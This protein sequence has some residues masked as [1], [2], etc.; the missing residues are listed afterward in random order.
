MNAKQPEQAMAALQQVHRPADAHYNMA[1]LYTKDQ[2]LVHAR[3]HATQALQLD[4]NLAPA[5]QLLDKI[6]APQMAQAAAGAMQVANNT[7]QTVNHVVSGPPVGVP[8]P[9]GVTVNGLPTGSPSANSVPATSY[10]P[11]AATTPPTVVR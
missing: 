11:T 8:Q 4:P 5:R 7:L 1:Y 9:T 6:G 10:V 3:E 2:D